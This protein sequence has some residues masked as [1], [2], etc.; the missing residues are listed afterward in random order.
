M[1]TCEMMVFKD[2]KDT[3]AISGFLLQDR[4]S[5]KYVQELVSLYD[6]Q[7]GSKKNNN[8]ISNTIKI[9]W[10]NF[11]KFDNVKIEASSKEGI[12]CIRADKFPDRTYYVGKPTSDQ[13]FAI[14][15][16][17]PVDQFPTEQVGLVVLTSDPLTFKM[18]TLSPKCGAN[19]ATNYYGYRCD[20]FDSRTWTWKRG[21]NDVVLPKMV[22]FVRQ[23]ESLVVNGLI[24]WLTTDG[25]VVVFDHEDE[26]YRRFPLPKGVNSLRSSLIEYEGK[27]G[28]VTTS[29]KEGKQLWVVEDDDDSR[30]H[31][32]WRLIKQQ[33]QDFRSIGILVVQ[34]TEVMKF[35]GFC[36]QHVFPFRSNFEPI[37]LEGGA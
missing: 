17:K 6:E 35:G 16:H 23:N 29:E 9:D 4:K 10:K 32:N 25:R 5:S 24:H 30:H 31:H 12:L 8:N 11:R 13:W 36:A 27:L 33:N 14:P 1:D 37:R 20:V 28:L 3:S 21:I 7:D 2:C 26:T 22:L 34:E 15:N 18:V 19:R